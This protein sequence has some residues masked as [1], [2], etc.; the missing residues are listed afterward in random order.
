MQKYYNLLL[1]YGADCG[2]MVYNWSSVCFHF[3]IGE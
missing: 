1:F 3:V 2:L